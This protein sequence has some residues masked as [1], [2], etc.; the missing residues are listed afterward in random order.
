MTYLV[1]VAE[2]SDPEHLAGD[3]VEAEA[4]AEVVPLPCVLDDLAAVDVG[5]HDNGGDRVAVPLLRLGAVLEP[6]R[7][8][9]ELATHSFIHSFI[10]T[11]RTQFDQHPREEEEKAMQ[12][13]VV[14]WY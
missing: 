10:H 12:C 3:L 8:H 13:N 1:E 5:R 9:G 7:L 14:V 6:P 11:A 2:M 4:E